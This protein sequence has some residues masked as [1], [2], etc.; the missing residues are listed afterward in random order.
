MKI[1]ILSMQRVQNFGSLLQSYGLKKMLEELGHTISFLDIEPN[2][3]ENRLLQGMKNQFSVEGEPGGTLIS[4]LRKMDQYFFNRLNNKRLAKKQDEQFEEFRVSTLGIRDHANSEV[5]DCCI[6]GSDEVFNCLTGAPWGFTTQLFGNVPQA[7]K[8]IT[9]AAS[10]GAT[11]YEDVPQPARDAIRRTFE[12]VD[13]FSVRDENTYRFVSELTNKPVLKH[14]DPVLVADFREEIQQAKLPEDLPER[15]CVIYSYY[16]RIS[17]KQDIEE[18]LSFCRRHGLTPLT[19]GAPQMWVHRHLA[20]DPFGALKVIQNAAFVITDTF[21][22]TIFSAK[23][24]KRFA[25]KVRASN[26]NKLED[27][28]FKIGVQAHRID[29]FRELDGRFAVE[30]NSAGVHRTVEHEKMLTREYLLNNVCKEA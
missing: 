4:K 11:R 25:V 30:N 20:L 29:S 8:V 22:G 23:Y 3:E 21:H 6:I 1:C 28:I 2:P 13:A 27:L 10:C 26:Q 17:Q 19:V 16:N 9:Y 12:K 15:Y 14:L 5:Y 7:R 18:I 24:A